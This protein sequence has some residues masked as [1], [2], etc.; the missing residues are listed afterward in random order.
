MHVSVY[1][2]VYGYIVN[3]YDK[4]KAW[5]SF[6]LCHRKVRWILEPLEPLDT[7]S[8]LCCVGPSSKS[9]S[10]EQLFLREATNFNPHESS[11]QGRYSF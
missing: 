8:A 9:I 11:L 6:G 10:F 7:R 5:P 2:Y 3:Q 1:V 4:L